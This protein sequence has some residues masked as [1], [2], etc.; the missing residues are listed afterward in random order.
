MRCPQ[1]VLWRFS[2]ESV[3]VWRRSLALRLVGL[4]TH[5]LSNYSERQFVLGERGVAF[6]LFGFASALCGHISQKLRDA[7]E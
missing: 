3:S 7:F 2:P 6:R 4:G 1:T 5:A